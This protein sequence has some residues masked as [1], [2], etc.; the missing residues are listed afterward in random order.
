MTTTPPTFLP[1][2]DKVIAL[3]GG[4][5]GIGLSAT[6]LLLSRGAT[7][8]IADNN[9][10]AL[11]AA[12][13]S[14]LSLCSS[15][16]QL[17]TT[18]LDVRSTPAVNA[19]IADTVAK[20]GPLDGAANIAGFHPLWGGDGTVTVAEMKDEDWDMIM[21]INST[22]VMR[23]LRAQL[24]KAGGMREGGSIVNVGSVAGLIGFAGNSAYVA[25]KHAVHGI[26]KSAAKE[27]GPRGIR[28]NAIA[29]GTINTP[30]VRALVT[31][32][33]GELP[34]VA[35]QTTPLAR[36]GQPEEAAELI[37][38][39]LSPQSSFVTGTIV[40]VDGGMLS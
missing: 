9:P 3:T 18:Q 32:D 1:F 40:R 15:P 24:G 6:R 19:W 23:C 31:N 34:Q 5:S 21:E 35:G 11:A 37:A 8:S 16:S 13:E 7:V 27:V 29:P 22:G 17:L 28:V 20:L 30:M 2:K 4:A 39:L 12:K 38:W 10:T 25:S 26:T 36:E 14:L 33:K